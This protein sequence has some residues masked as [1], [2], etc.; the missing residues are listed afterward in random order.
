MKRWGWRLGGHQR[1]RQAIQTTTMAIKTLNYQAP[2]V[3]STVTLQED[4][5]VREVSGWRFDTHIG[6]TEVADGTVFPSVRA[7][8]EKLNAEVMVRC[9]WIKNR[10]EKLKAV[11]VASSVVWVESA[12]HYMEVRRGDQTRFAAGE[13][14]TW[15]TVERWLDYLSVVAAAVERT[16][17]QGDPVRRVAVKEEEVE[18]PAPVTVVEA[19]VLAAPA[20]AVVEAFDAS[21][22]KNAWALMR[23]EVKKETGTLRSAHLIQLCQYLLDMRPAASA[24]LAENP[25]WHYSARAIVQDLGWAAEHQEAKEAVRRF[26]EKF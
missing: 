7:W 19:V 24:W 20:P 22:F 18:A 5:S 17:V 1:A 14:R 21:R 10:A 8:V 3:G 26:L 6:R 11:D 15:A 12:G 4:G 16:R 2:W 25:F 13:R 23:D 9:P